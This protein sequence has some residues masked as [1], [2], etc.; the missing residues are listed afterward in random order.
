MK[1][2]A[3]CIFIIKFVTKLTYHMKKALYLTCFAAACYAAGAFAIPAKKGVRT[4]EQ[5]DGSFIEVI[6]SGDEH[7]HFTTT[8][9]GKL[10]QLD[11]D[12]FYKIA[13]ISE[14]GLV[15]PTKFKPGTPEGLAVAISMDGSGAE[16]LKANFKGKRRAPQSGYGLVSST[17]PAK[18]KSKGLI[19]LVEYQDVKF[20]S[21]SEYGACDARTYF[22]EMINGENF[23]LHRGTGSA[24]AYFT[25]Q[26]RG[27]FTPDFD[28]LG[29]VELPHPRSYYGKN[30]KWGD[31]ANAHLMV[32]D[33][34]E[35]LD[36]DVNFSVY[37]TDNDGIIDNVYIFYAGQ[38]EADFGGADT[39]W[40]HSWDVRDAGIKKRADGKLIALYA[41]SNEWEASNPCGV[42][43]FI[44]EFSH[45]MGLPDLYH[46]TNVY[47]TYTPGPYSVLDYGP[48]NNSGRTPPN[49]GAYEK[50]ALG[51]EEPITLEGPA[52]ISLE[53]ITTGQ[54]A[55]IPT[56]KDTEFFL[57]ENR[58]LEGW[59]AYL[60]NHGMLVW[61]IDYVPSVFENNEVNNTKNHQYV[62]IVEANNS[63]NMSSVQTMRGYTFP[64]TSNNTSFTPSTTPALKDW[65]GKAIDL[66]IT[67]IAE[68]RGVI[69]F[70]VAGGANETSV[71]LTPE[72][73][74]APV[75]YFT[76]QGMK[77]ANPQKGSIVIERKG[78]ASRKI[79]Y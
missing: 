21:E 60:P 18:G 28:V 29:P 8:P 48:Y 17:Y 5:P 7:F 45:V 73:E 33:A 15:V 23:T 35:I 51:W 37:D 62:D 36:P 66:P 76:L 40:P 4:L 43:T 30:D 27:Q 44:H 22:N 52:T 9:D 11:E 49:Y 69:T 25:E 64:G 79:K 16:R 78:S 74:T 3:N 41:C 71:S 53:K 13:E 32:T 20:K 2:I 39:V 12:G 24:L 14:E 57:L 6:V 70:D 19:I 72:D 59:D 10:L 61:H 68:S 1:W 75:E 65:S 47:A 34:I 26:S 54:F 58:Q 56:D 63:A 31:D 38:G 77:I 67:N 42:G 46:T 55:L 50:I